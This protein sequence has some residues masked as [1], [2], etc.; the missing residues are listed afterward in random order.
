M[1]QTIKWK[2][3]SYVTIKQGVFI[4]K[5]TTVTLRKKY[6]VFQPKA[7]PLLWEFPVSEF[8]AG[9]AYINHFFLKVFMLSA[10]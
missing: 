9:A 8:Y 6:P 2:V 4:E 10:L 7:F 5:F 3:V 1:R